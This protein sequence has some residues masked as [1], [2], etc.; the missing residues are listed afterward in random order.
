MRRR[1]S[2]DRAQEIWEELTLLPI[3]QSSLALEVTEL[4][5]LAVR[6]NMSVYDVCYLRIARLERLPLASNDHVLLETAESHGLAVMQ[7]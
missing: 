2:G 3:R 6:H 5:A 4:P 1:L 7:P